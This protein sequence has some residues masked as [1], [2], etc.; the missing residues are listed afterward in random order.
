VVQGNICANNARLGICVNAFQTGILLSGNICRDNPANLSLRGD[1][2][3]STGD[4]CAGKGG[5]VIEGHGNQVN[6]LV[7][8]C[9]LNISATDLNYTGGIIS[10]TEETPLQV[11]MEI[12]RKT[13]DRRTAPV[14]GIRIRQVTI[15]N[16]RTAVTVAGVVKD[17]RLTDNRIQAKGAAFQVAEECRDEV[18]T[19]GNEVGE[20]AR[21]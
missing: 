18:K 3:S 8:L 19:D 7:A 21:R 12:A 17:V 5:I 11:A 10:G 6:G 14:D 13:E 4:F 15:K 2:C 9:P 1:Y 16:C 20:G